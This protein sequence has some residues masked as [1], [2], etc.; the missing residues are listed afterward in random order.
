MKDL[1]SFTLQE[2]VINTLVGA[3]LYKRTD[4]ETAVLTNFITST[5]VLGTSIP[6]K[7]YLPSQT[8]ALQSMIFVQ[9][10]GES[11]GYVERA[12]TE[13]NKDPKSCTSVTLL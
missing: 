8:N 7:I 1:N 13:R 3:S 10:E 12:E 4:D 11:T 9:A 2:S 5:S 6:S